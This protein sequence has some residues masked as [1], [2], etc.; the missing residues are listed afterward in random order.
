[1]VGGEAWSLSV[2]PRSFYQI[3]RR[4]CPAELIR[5]GNTHFLEEGRGRGVHDGWEV[6]LRCSRESVQELSGGGRGT[7]NWH[8]ESFP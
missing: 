1:M 4:R 5:L 2:T 6:S 7:A 3:V 8:S